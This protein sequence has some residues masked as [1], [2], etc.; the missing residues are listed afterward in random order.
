M[1][2]R[3]QT[4]NPGLPRDAAL[5]QVI[6]KLNYMN[7]GHINAHVDVTLAAN[8]A[9]TTLSDPR[10]GSNSRL[11][12]MA[13]TAH[14]GTALAAGIYVTARMKGS[15]TLTHH[16]TADTDKTFTVAILGA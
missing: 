3:T 16:N 11:V 10:I 9:T 14:A 8:A 7:Q 6:D 5:A 12:F 2:A 1:S 15:C 4:G 13:Q